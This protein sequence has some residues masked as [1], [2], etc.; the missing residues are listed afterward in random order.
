MAGRLSF[1]V[2]VVFSGMSY[3]VGGSTLLTNLGMFTLTFLCVFFLFDELRKFPRRMGVGGIILYG[4][5]LVWFCYDYLYHWIDGVAPEFSSIVTPNVVAKDAFSVCLFFAMAVFVLDVGWFSAAEKFI[6]A[7]PEPAGETLYLVVICTALIVG[8]IPYFLLVN[9]PPYMALWKTITLD[10]NDVKWSVGRTYLGT[11][12]NINYNWGGYIVVLLQIGTVSGILGAMYSILIARTAV[13]KMFGGAIWLFWVLDSYTSLRR[14]DMAFMIL[15][16]V[17]FLYFK[18][19][20]QALGYLRKTGWKAYAFAG[21]LGLSLFLIVQYQ[22]ALREGGDVELFSPRGNT[23]FS[24]SIRTWAY[25]PDRN[26]GHYFYDSIPGETILRPIPD[27]LF[28]LAIDPIP[29]ALWNSKPLDDF[30][31]WHNVF[32][33]HEVNGVTGTGVSSGIVGYFYFRF[34]LFGVIEGGL[35]F[36]WL[37]G[38]SE[39]A[40]RRSGGRPIALLFVMAYATFLFRDFRDLD[41]HA[42]DGVLEAGVALYLIVKLTGAAPNPEPGAV[43]WEGLSTAPAS[44]REVMAFE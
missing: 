10:S 43:S 17:G 35:F 5:V 3:L 9:E 14:G 6:V 32:E 8:L 13:G 34:G 39:R 19:Q 26:N 29:R 18:Y 40:L 1:F 21:I 41:W 4:G 12:V 7:V 24:E 33:T 36:G 31:A 44:G 42:F 27:C 22:T 15:P 25:V 20:R 16:V 28:W 37:A 2:P 30:Y 38:L 11:A 23:M